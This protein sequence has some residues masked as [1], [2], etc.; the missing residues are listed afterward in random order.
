MRIT[1][2]TYNASIYCDDCKPDNGCSDDRCLNSECCPQPVFST[3]DE[4]DTPQHCATC[5]VF[6]KNALT[7]DGMEWLRES[8]CDDLG[9]AE[10]RAEWRTFYGLDRPSTWP[11]LLVELYAQLADE[12]TKRM[13]GIY[14]LYGTAVYPLSVGHQESDL[15][16]LADAFATAGNTG[17]EC[18]GETR[19]MSAAVLAKFLA[20]CLTGAIVEH[21]GG[22]I[23]DGL[24]QCSELPVMQS[25]KVRISEWKEAA[26]QAAIDILKDAFSIEVVA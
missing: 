7:G 24:P 9:N 23:L 14:G 2:W 25:D 26:K 4:A 3:S 18:C 12:I 20:E 15:G 13:R 10:V 1:S 22:T 16:R 11:S 19:L 5:N 21:D 17:F 6:L 8:L